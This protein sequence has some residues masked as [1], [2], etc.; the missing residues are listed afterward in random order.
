MGVRLRGNRVPGESE[1][2]H[3]YWR[4]V[5]T[6]D[7]YFQASMD[8]VAV[9]P[10]FDLYNRDWP[11]LTWQFPHPP[12]KFVPRGAASA[13]AAPSTRWWPAG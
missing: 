5:G 12:A 8:L 2:E 1:R 6:L 9:Q 11:I 3:G 4:D 10:V 13:S 7:A